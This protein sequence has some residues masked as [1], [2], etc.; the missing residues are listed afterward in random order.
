[1]SRVTANK[2]FLRMAS[3]FTVYQVPVK[4]FPVSRYLA[5]KGFPISKVLNCQAKA[6]ISTAENAC[7]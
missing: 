1:M 2:V 3:V 4:G 6:I 5:V 7:V